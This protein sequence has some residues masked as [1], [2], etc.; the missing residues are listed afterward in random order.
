[1]LCSGA[2]ADPLWHWR[3]VRG[4]RLDL[5]IFHH[6]TFLSVMKKPAAA[7]A[8]RSDMLPTATVADRV[9]LLHSPSPKTPKQQPPSPIMS[10]AHCILYLVDNAQLCSDSAPTFNCE[11]GDSGMSLGRSIGRSTV[12]VVALVH[13]YVDRET[14]LW[15]ENMEHLSSG[16]RLRVGAHRPV[17]VEAAAP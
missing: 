12:V 11:S 10:L 14:F 16:A 9:R 7:S 1:M 17:L 15:F 13:V 2:C 4:L 8:V 3:L 5:F 6:C